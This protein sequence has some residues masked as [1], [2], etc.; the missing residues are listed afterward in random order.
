MLTASKNFVHLQETY[1]LLKLENGEEKQEKTRLSNSMPMRIR[2]AFTV[3]KRTI[4]SGKLKSSQLNFL[5]R[6][7]MSN[8]L[9]LYMHLNMY[10]D[11][12]MVQLSSCCSL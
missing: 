6:G 10:S 1:N 12:N 4:K 2:N 8:I 3:K 9:A 7:W 11:T 5:C